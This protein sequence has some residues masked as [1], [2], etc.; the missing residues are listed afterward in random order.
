MLSLMFTEVTK[1]NDLP[2]NLLSALCYVESA[3]KP[4]AVH[5]D[6]GGGNSLGICQIKLDT[7]KTMG[8]KG[9]EK[10][11]MVPKTN[12]KYAGKY[13]KKQLLRYKHD[14]RKA[15]AAYNAGSY[16]ENKKKQCINSS[17]VRKVFYA[18]V[19]KNNLDQ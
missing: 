7:A 6:D 2:D 15:V 1:T 11:L 18:W 14:V 4:N 9:T 19:Q 12:I 3:H 16:R 13:L 5:K 10:D 8:F 17:Y